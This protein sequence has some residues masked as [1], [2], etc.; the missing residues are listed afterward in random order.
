M[1]LN[2]VIAIILRFSPNLMPLHFAAR[3]IM[4]QWL[5]IDL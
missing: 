2:G 4:S 3:L 1:T 5:K